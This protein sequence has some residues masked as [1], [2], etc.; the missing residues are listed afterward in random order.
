MNRMLGLTVASAL[1]LGTAVAQADDTRGLY[2]GVNIGATKLDIDKNAYDAAL[3][4]ALAQSG[5]TVT[6][7]TSSSSENDASFGVFAG[8]RILPYLAVEAEWMTLGTGKYEARGDVTN[9]ETAD[10]LRFNA[11]TDSKGVA[12]SA[13]GIWPISRTWDV[14]ARLG[15][16]FATTTL[17]ASARTN[18]ASVNDNV[19]EDTQDMLYG[20]G[21]TYHYSSTWGVRLDYQHFDGLGDSKT[22]GETNV[23]R[24]AVSWVY[25]FR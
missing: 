15:M 9:G 4:D 7:A 19:S 16:I 8:Y 25:S 22:T 14:Y 12:A 5:V 20:V 1:A 21:A 3:N 6:S 11:E 2:L 10:T 17:T 24:L 13:L 18:A 23:D